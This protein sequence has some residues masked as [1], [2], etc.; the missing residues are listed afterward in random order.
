MLHLAGQ[1]LIYNKKCCIPHS[2]ILRDVIKFSLIYNEFGN[3]RF[4][5]NVTTYQP[6]LNA[7]TTETIILKGVKM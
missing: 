5:R 7:Q 1:L 2:Y 4:L 3:S 6:Y